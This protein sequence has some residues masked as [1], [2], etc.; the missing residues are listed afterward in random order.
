MEK[1]QILLWPKNNSDIIPFKNGLLN[2][3]TG[4]LLAHNRKDSQTWVIP[5]EYNRGADCPRIKNW[6]FNAAGKDAATVEFL[7][8]WIYALIT[9]ETS[10][11]GFLHLKGRGGTGKSTFINLMQL[12]IGQDNAITTSLRELEN[13]RFETAG[14]MG[15]ALVVINDAEKYKGGASVLKAMTGRDALRYEKKNKQQ[16]LSFIYRGQMVIAS[17]DDLM[18]FEKDSGLERRRFTVLFDEV[19]S[20]EEKRRFL[21][22]CYLGDFSNYLAEEAPGLFNWCLQLGRNQALTTLRNPPDAI[23]KANR[24]AAENNNP[25]LAW[26]ALDC[27]LKSD[28]MALMGAKREESISIDMGEGE[29]RT[30]REFVNADT[31]LYPNFLRFC[32]ERNLMPVSERNF[33]AMVIDAASTVYGVKIRK[34]KTRMGLALIGIR[35]KTMRDMADDE[36]YLA[37]EMPPA[38]IPIQADDQLEDEAPRKARH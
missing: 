12:I 30:R 27:V 22:S 17:N 15:K 20:E 1:D 9:R 19:V 16:K 32:A 21:A 38:K 18:T 24:E 13:N 10:F 14:F 31:E 35:L 25:V 23:R 11:H 26:L 3:K 6:L 36:A 28:A 33:S 2:L 5:H 4:E 29:R 7:R 34:H 37:K 8:A